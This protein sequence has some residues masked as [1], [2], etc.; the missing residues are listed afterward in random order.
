MHNIDFLID[1]TVLKSYKDGDENARRFIYKAIDGDASVGICSYSLTMLW[2]SPFFDRK[3]EIGFTSLL[4]FVNVIDLDVESAIKAGHLLRQSSSV[5]VGG[6]T[7]EFLE[8]V[9]VESVALFSGCPVVTESD[10]RIGT[11]PSMYIK[12]ND[13]ALNQI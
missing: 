8:C 5:E 10:V 6:F 7:M 11:D 12:L 4:E 3:S 13:V 9:I 2:G 1:S